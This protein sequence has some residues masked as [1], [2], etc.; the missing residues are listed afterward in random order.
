[1]GTNRFGFSMLSK[2]RYNEAYLEEVMVDKA[3]GEFL[4]KSPDGRVVSY[5]YNTKLHNIHSDIKNTMHNHN[6]YGHLY[7]CHLTDP[8]SIYPLSI[9]SSFVMDIN[10]ITLVKPTARCMLHID[11]AGMVANENG[12]VYPNGSNDIYVY[13]TEIQFDTINKNGEYGSYTTRI[14]EEIS[15]YELNNKVVSPV[16]TDMKITSV[17]IV[18]LKFNASLK[19]SALI[20]N[21]IGII[22]EA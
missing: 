5:D 13:D 11:I 1:M 10:A 8:T 7:E 9:D 4:I 14:T 17:R 12:F 15:L 2:S 19:Y 22:A 18:G 20:L 21:Y 3:T 16:D 6:L